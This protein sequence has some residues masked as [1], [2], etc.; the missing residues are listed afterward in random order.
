MSALPH[1]DVTNPLQVARPHLR[2]VPGWLLYRRL[3]RGQGLERWRP[4]HDGDK[5][6]VVGQTVSALWLF[7]HMDGSA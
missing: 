6:P 5:E 7:E 4:A 1:P 2:P 3:A